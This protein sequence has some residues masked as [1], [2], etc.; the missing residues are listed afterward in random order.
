MN[1]SYKF[2]V[3]DD[4]IIN[5]DTTT[6]EN[7]GAITAIDRTTY[8]NLAVITFTTAIGGTAFTTA[9]KAHI[10]VEAGT[11]GNLY[12]DAIAILEKTVDTGT[13]VNSQ[14]ANVDVILGNVLLYEGM[15]TNID[16]ASKTDLSAT[17]I[18]QLLMIR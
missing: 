13:G 15:L 6:A 18:G 5:D 3:G 14:G 9:R 4:V 8:P 10:L 12:S 11:S 7:V 16:A 17:S 2:A 1:D